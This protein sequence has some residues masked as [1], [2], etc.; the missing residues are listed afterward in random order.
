VEGQAQAGQTALKPGARTSEL[1][2]LELRGI[3]AGPSAYLRS[4]RRWSG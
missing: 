4:R 1:A 2:K 3:A